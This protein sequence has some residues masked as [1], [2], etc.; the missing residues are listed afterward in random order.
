MGKGAPVTTRPSPYVGP[1]AFERGERLFGRDREIARLVDLVIA[2]R[3]VLLYSP[4]G[5]GKTSLLRAGLVPELEKEGFRVLPEIRVT[6]E[7][8]ALGDAVTPLN[9]YLM[10][11]LLSLEKDVPPDRQ[12]DLDALAR[13]TL[14]DYLHRRRAEHGRQVSG[15]QDPPEGSRQEAGDGFGDNEVLIIDQFEEVLTA[16]VT[17][18]DA[19]AFFMAEL[20]AALRNP[21]RWAIIAMREDFVAGLD[22]F[23]RLLPTRLRT[24]FRLDLLKED[25]ARIAIQ[26]PAQQVGV[27]FSDD[28]AQTLVDDLRKI[29]IPGRNGLTEVL[30]P[31]IEPVQ[32][33]VVCRRLWDRLPPGT[34]QIT[35]VDVED[36]EDV[37]RAL[38]CYYADQIH[39]VV[40][41][42]GADERMIRD[43][44]DQKLISEQGLRSQV[45]NGPVAGAAD[46]QR[47]LRLLEDAR[48]VRAEARR[49]TRWFELAH[50][51][52]IEAVRANN[53]EWREANLQPFQ[54]QAVL[55]QHQGQPLG[56]LLANDA[57]TAADR[58]VRE[59]SCQLTSTEQEFLAASHR[60][61]NER[62]REQR[63]RRLI[64]GLVSVL[65][66]V[67]VF[68]AFLLFR[69]T[70]QAG[71]RALASQAM[72]QLAVDPAAAVETALAA[73][74]AASTLEAQVAL[75]RSLAE[76]HLRAVLGGQTT[77]TSA[78]AALSPDGRL[79]VTVN[80]DAWA[81]V[82]DTMTGRPMSVLH[83]LGPG[84]VS[85]MAFDPSGSR[86]VTASRSEVQIWDAS[87]GRRLST[88]TGHRG[89]VRSAEWSPDG[90]K[91]VTASHDL[92]AR[93]WNAN[94]GEVSQVLGGHEAG[95][96]TATFSSNGQWV[97]TAASDGTVRVWDA[98]TGHE[99]AR[100]HLH[101]KPVSAAAF[102]PDGT[103]VISAGEDHQAY[104]WQ[105]A[106]DHPPIL[107]SGH[108]RAV[109]SARFSPDGRYIV[110]AGDQIARLWNAHDGSWLVD[111]HGHTDQVHAAR[112]SPDSSLV[113]TAS[114][115][116]TARV[117]DVSSG[118]SLA[119]L[120][121]D[122]GP[123]YD[124]M[125]APNFDDPFRVKVLTAGADG[126]AR[127]W[128]PLIGRVLLG[129]TD[130]VRGADF[131]ADGGSVVAAGADGVVRVWRAG[132]GEQPVPASSTTL[133]SVAF[134]PDGRYVVTGGA[135]GTVSIWDWQARMKVAERVLGAPVTSV[136]FDP[137]GRFVAIA[138][139][140]MAH[141]WQ[142]DVDKLLRSFGKGL[143]RV[144]DVAFSRDSTRLVTAHEDAIARV[145]DT[146]TG[147]LLHTLAG[148]TG[149]VRSVALSPDSTF[150][151]TAGFDG[152]ART[153]DAATG[154]P[155]QML[156][157]HVSRL[158][159]A[160]FSPDGDRI[161]TG[162]ADGT[163][164]V[165]EARTGQ[166]L[167][168]L[169]LHAD[170]VNSAQFSPDS[171]WI[172]T[173]SDDG[174]VRISDCQTCSRSLDE[175][176]KLARERQPVRER[177][178]KPTRQ[179]ARPL[180]LSSI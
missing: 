41:K 6:A 73:L 109:K 137:S 170:R 16:D 162:A 91:V 32:L 145:W 59:H 46:G 69:Q 96:T 5:A 40:T 52:L 54:R 7:L 111:L 26:E 161:V 103:Q 179:A 148:H 89:L 134:S 95:L 155:S 110:T 75:R 33:Q 107:L 76:S 135:G 71:S 35:V 98:Q 55:W 165:W 100:R 149:F 129:A 49:G 159:D 127:V 37:D 138:G 147:T 151:V 24:T 97:L 38:A 84:P 17:D 178:Q 29:R 1:R 139:T 23:L 157:G 143:G 152:T 34:S 62:R 2:E 4:S 176:R 83:P 10:S 123:V 160:A 114:D 13:M 12:Q 66:L 163:A 130:R 30:G 77:S 90:A 60:A 45:I 115:D 173:A 116:G 86:V 50:D 27:D 80:A 57:L 79:A 177:S 74:D 119:Q 168:L 65:A 94:T 82:W 70:Q 44:F 136:E 43:W 88:L 156:R 144:F 113:V 58:W 132:T 118:A 120:R 14:V 87:N 53:V 105:W 19:K 140:D 104:L 174:T 21:H 142:W 47:V 51:R 133:N 25:S 180:Q 175:M 126:A 63:V 167:G 146:S 169:P 93:I 72:A 61:R 124:A 112:F 78:K 56:L 39:A 9:R 117:W 20:G 101:T 158:Y 28:A 81:R 131:S 92:T 121:G 31:Y 172:L 36:V 150:I 22:P 106:S 8:A 3:I 11:T 68:T 99:L 141:V 128:E 85:V 125:F 164:G 166:N 15:N 18:L 48:L 122:A 154:R 108:R 64:L 153:W 102:S 42:T 67:A 171:R